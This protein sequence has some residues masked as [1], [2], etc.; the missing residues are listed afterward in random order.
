[1]LAVTVGAAAFFGSGALRY[2]FRTH[3]GPRSVDAA[4]RQFR[5]T[6][7][8]P[9]EAARRPA[10]GVYAATG[11]GTEHISFPP[12]SQRDGPGIPVTVQLLTG[13]CWRWRIDYN[14][15]HW[16]EYDFCPTSAG[17]SMFANRNAQSWDFGAMRVS[18]RAEFTCDP[19]G[20]VVVDRARSGDEFPNDCTGSNSAVSGT[21]VA[22]GTSTILGAETVTIGGRAV[23]TVHEH[24]HQT[25]SG[26][27]QGTIDED[28]WVATADGMLVRADRSFALRSA[29]PIGSISYTERGSWQLDSLTP[30]T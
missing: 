10:A 23:A 3:P 28:W 4:L 20:P 26:G 22:R 29:S 30:R 9:A 15:A 13:G 14:T 16:Q 7:S 5:S 17:A 1:L 8:S 25:M 27:Q 6:T 21:S 18:N 2:A 11:G 24:R 19:P 12:N